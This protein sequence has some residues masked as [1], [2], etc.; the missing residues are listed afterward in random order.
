[1]I[2]LVV[3]GFETPGSK[4][5]VKRQGDVENP[6]VP[7]T[8]EVSLYFL[9]PINGRRPE[10]QQRELNPESPLRSV[11]MSSNDKISNNSRQKLTEILLHCYLTHNVS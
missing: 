10:R 4:A 5:A 7:V 8:F 1:M 9:T 6:E 11:K 3:H 2:S